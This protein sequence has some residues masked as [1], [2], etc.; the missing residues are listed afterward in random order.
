MSTLAEGSLSRV[1]R[2]K[3]RTNRR[4][5][6]VSRRLF[7]EKGIYWAKIEDITE[8]ADQGKGTFYKYFDS[9]EAIICALLKEGLDE[10]TFQTEQAVQKVPTG[11][12]T[13]SAAIEARVDFFLNC[14]E[15]LLF[16][17]QVR[18][19]MQLQVAVANDLRAIYDAHLDRLAEL[20]KPAMNGVD[21][22]GSARDIARAM[23]AYTSGVLTYDVLFEGQEST[24]RRRNYFVD[25]LDRSL[26]PLLKPNKGSR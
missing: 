1:E 9:K 17:H 23:A 6:E 13:L 18:G 7:S 16:F 12:K 21:Q 8:L 15:Y 14:P 20:I 2:R 11:P 5:L 4:F 3:A 25:M 24:E 22:S 19:L 26:Q 10:L